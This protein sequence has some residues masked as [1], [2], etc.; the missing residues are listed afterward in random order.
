MKTQI[1]GFLSLLFLGVASLHAAHPNSVGSSSK[2]TQSHGVQWITSYEDAVQEAQKTGKP[3]ALFFTGSDWC[4][5]C[6]K[7]EQEVL[8][9][10]EFASLT[11]DKIIFVKLDFP[12]HHPLEPRL[13][14]QN[15]QLRDKYNINSYPTL[16]VIDAAGKKIGTTGYRQGG[17]RR[18]AQHLMAM[19]SSFS[20]H[21]DTIQDIADQDLSFEQIKDLYV[22]AKNLGHQ[23]DSRKI[24]QQGLKKDKEDFF[25]TEQYRFLVE[26][27]EMYDKDTLR[28]R[29]K[30][31]SHRDANRL[32]KAHHDV[33]IIDFQ[34]L[35]HQMKR[36][37]AHPAVAVA[38][39]VDYVERFGASDKENAWRMNMTISQVYMEQGHM[40][41]ALK[42]AESAKS[43]APVNVKGDIDKAISFI[44]HQL[45]QKN[46]S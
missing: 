6:K 20:K 5:W 32:R 26:E 22:K 12:M 41:D 45:D 1:F 18:F 25:L 23:E 11:K 35:H 4:T 7:L 21:Q 16:L 37:H 9:T 2:N 34:A 29:S 24:L 43:N 14:R 15:Q 44:R 40:Q 31:L 36:D 17:G 27:G 33:A 3:I 30:L 39:L 13:A 8:D 19:V 42:Y 10:G 38:P 46:E 28:L